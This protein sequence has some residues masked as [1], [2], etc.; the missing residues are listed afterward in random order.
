[1]D[2]DAEILTRVSKIEH[3]LESVL[4]EDS[5]EDWKLAKDLGELLIRIDGE[6]IMGHA[7]VA[8]ASRHLGDLKRALSE[9]EQCRIRVPH[10]PPQKEMFLSFLAEEERF[11]SSKD[12][13]GQ[14]QR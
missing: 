12:G 13:K 2:A 8:R 10:P 3:F 1:M 5:L 9:L 14:D 6:D 11:V 4:Y 7:L